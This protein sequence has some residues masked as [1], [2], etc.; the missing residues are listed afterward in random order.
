M[1]DGGFEFS[2]TH[3]G[4]GQ[5]QVN[6]GMV[7]IETKSCSAAFDRSVGV[8]ERAISFAE[9][10]VDDGITRSKLG[11]PAD[12]QYRLLRIALAGSQ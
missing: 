6:V 11:C 10:G 4:Q 9:V 5:V 3:Q 1:A 12:Q 7:G 2:H 8:T